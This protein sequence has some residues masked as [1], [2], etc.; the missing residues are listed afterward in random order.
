MDY[1]EIQFNMIKTI[2][3][4]K[5]SNNKRTQKETR[6]IQIQKKIHKI[7]KHHHKN[8]LK[9]IGEQ[10]RGRVLK[11]AGV[12]VSKKKKTQNQKIN[13]PQCTI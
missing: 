7:Q 1:D 12:G 10:S 13:T 3:K 6:K 2:M 8:Q 4:H 9:N 5:R 11:A